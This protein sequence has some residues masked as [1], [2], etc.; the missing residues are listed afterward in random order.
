MVGQALA[1]LL[2]AHLLFRLSQCLQWCYLGDPMRWKLLMLAA[3]SI[4]AAA[5]LLY[6]LRPP[7]QDRAIQTALSS[8]V[9]DYRKIIVLMDGADALDEAA[10]A[11]CN[12]A[13]QAL[14]WRK[15]RAL[16]RIAATFAEPSTRATRVRQ[17][18]RYLTEDRSLHDADKLAFLDLVSELAESWPGDLRALLDNLQSIQLAYREE[19]TRI[20]SQFAT[21]G[22][23]GAREEWDSYVAALRK[24][25]S[26]KAKPTSMA[27][28]SS[29]RPSWEPTSV[30]SCP[31]SPGR[32]RR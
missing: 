2:S 17:L 5:V 4:S 14:F 12:L 3:A 8:V 25:Y 26:W 27:T 21:R 9:D 29:R 23:S 22:G 28:A 24:G 7:R 11:R 1:C 18:T 30:R 13:G 31:P 6:F 32:R 10:H 20:F 19:V 16:D 15:Q